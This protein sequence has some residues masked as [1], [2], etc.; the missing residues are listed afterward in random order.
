MSSG[1]RNM[2]LYGRVLNVNIDLIDT[3][4]TSML[5][6]VLFYSIDHVLQTCQSD[7]KDVRKTYLLVRLRNYSI[8]V[9]HALISGFSSLICLCVYP[10]LV[11]NIIESENMFAYH[12]L[13]FA[14]GY[15]IHDIYHNLCSSVGLRS[16]EIILHHI[17]VLTCFY[18]VSCY[19]ILVCYALFGLLME[20]NS[21]FLHARK[22][23]ILL[24]IDPE[25]LAY[26]VNAAAN[27]VT[28]IIFRIFLTLLL[29]GWAI[30]NRNKLPIVVSW[31]LIT[32][33][34]VF[35]TMNFVLFFRVVTAERRILRSTHSRLCQ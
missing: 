35:T 25:S 11:N 10:D 33:F 34:T 24:N 12:I 21:I 9:I 30:I 1:T 14:T 23:M 28:F 22:L 3:H 15:F 6:F 29:F 31:I 20:L 32:S 5:T 18:V 7:N 27:I 4:T 17:T 26:R 16:F 19:R 13:G 8:S 2:T